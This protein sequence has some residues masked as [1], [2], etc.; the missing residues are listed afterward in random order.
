[1]EFVFGTPPMSAGPPAA[2][3]VTLPGGHLQMTIP[4]RAD[5]PALLTVE[6]SGDLSDWRSGE[7]A[8]QIV[9]DGASV[10]VVRDLTAS[11]P[12]HPARFMR[13]KVES[14]AP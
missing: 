14:A 12:L 8:T 11:G 6:V 2:T 5:R 9:E 1:L 10:L 13:L 3:P 7:A 4:R